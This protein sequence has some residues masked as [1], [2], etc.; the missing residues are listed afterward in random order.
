MLSYPVRLAQTTEGKVRVIFLDVPEAVAEANTE[1]EALYR[2]KFALELSL[3]NYVLHD[4]AIP[5]PT[6]LPGAPVV[7][8][9]KF[10]LAADP[11]LAEGTG[12]VEE[13]ADEAETAPGGGR[14]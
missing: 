8:T 11:E 5:T 9:D 14:Y 1:E 7:T 2:A 6:D 3:G 4:R 10:N 12:D 13:R